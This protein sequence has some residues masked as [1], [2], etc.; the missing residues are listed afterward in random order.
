MSIDPQCSPP[1]NPK[2]INISNIISQRNAVD[3]MRTLSLFFFLMFLSSGSFVAPTIL[4][5]IDYVVVPWIWW[6]EVGML[7]RELPVF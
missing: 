7:R 5:T 6:P 2:E 1:N 3:F 4:G